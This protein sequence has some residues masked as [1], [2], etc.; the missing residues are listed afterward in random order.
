MSYPGARIPHS[1]TTHTAN[2]AVAATQRSWQTF[3]ATVPVG[4]LSAA[5]VA[6]GLTLCFLGKRIFKL[7]LGITGF[8]GGTLLGVLVL[9][10]L[11]FPPN[12]ASWNRWAVVV[13][14]GV[15]LMAACLLAWRMAIYMAGGLGGLLA[16]LI[17]CYLLPNFVVIEWWSRLLIDLILVGVGVFLVMRYEDSV[18]AVTTAFMGALSTVLGVDF[19]CQTGF[20]NHLVEMLTSKRITLS[21]MNPQQY[22]MLIM[23]VALAVAGLVSQF[24]I[25]PKGYARE[26]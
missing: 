25:K 6:A 19:Y 2:K 3:T 14:C 18:I 15:A 7:F 16:S 17:L 5:C 24:L 20:V 1:V 4:V 26:Q 9:G 21:A 22:Y 8:L 23:L 13:L 11:G 10:F 12:V